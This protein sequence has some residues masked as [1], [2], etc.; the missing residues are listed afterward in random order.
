MHWLTTQAAATQ[1]SLYIRRSSPPQ[2]RH[3]CSIPACRVACPFLFKVFSQQF[4]GRGGS[5][6]VLKQISLVL[7]VLYSVTQ[8]P[9]TLFH[10][11]SNPKREV[12]RWSTCVRFETLHNVNCFKR[13]IDLQGCTIGCLQQRYAA[14]VWQVLTLVLWIDSW[15]SLQRR[16]QSLIEALDWFIQ[17]LNSKLV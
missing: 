8:L 13:L 7:L 5:L 14:H 6:Q 16:L 4:V 1:S 3:A 2:C 11:K 10:N 17:S 12:A 15:G 9:Q